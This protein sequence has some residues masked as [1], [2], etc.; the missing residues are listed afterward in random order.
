MRQCLQRFNPWSWGRKFKRLSASLYVR[1]AQCAVRR[2]PL[3]LTYQKPFCI[4]VSYGTVT[5]H[6][7]CKFD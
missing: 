5:A 2:L 4:D 3:A 6:N 7:K 1:R